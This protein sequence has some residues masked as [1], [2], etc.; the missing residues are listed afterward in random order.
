MD[1]NV[2]TDALG[3][4][5]RTV[6]LGWFTSTLDT[7]YS[8]KLS[9][10]DLPPLPS[11]FASEQSKKVFQAESMKVNNLRGKSPRVTN[12]WT[13]SEKWL[14][15]LASSEEKNKYGVKPLVRVILK[16]YGWSIAKAGVVK[17]LTTALS[18][19]GPILLGYIVKYLENGVTQRNLHRGIL[20]IALL[21]GSSVASAVLN[22]NYNVRT[23]IIK[24]NMQGALVRIVFTRCLSL[25]I[26]AKKELFLSDSQVN[27][28]VQVDVDQVSNC[29][30]SI[31]DLWALPVQIVVACALLYLN[32]KVAFLAGMFIIIIMIPLNSM[33]A[34]RIGSATDS[35]MKA[36]DSRIKIVT[37][38][39][40]NVVSMK[41][42]GLEGAVLGASGAFRKNEVHHLAM[43]K[44][45]DAVCVFLW[46]LTPV[47]VPFA[48]FLTT[49]YMN[50]DLSAS[51]VIT[52]IALLNMLIFPMNALP[53]VINGFME[54]RVSL[55]RLAKVLSSEDGEQLHVQNRFMRKSRHRVTFA[56]PSQ[57]EQQAVLT[58]AGG[59]ES[60]AS[61]GEGTARDGMALNIPTT[62][63]SWSTTYQTKVLMNPPLDPLSA[64]SHQQP[65]GADLEAQTLSPLL[66]GSSNNTVNAEGGDIGTPFA[67]SINEIKLRPGQ[68]MGVIGSTGSGK[69]SLLLGILG[70]IRGHKRLNDTGITD[71]LNIVIVVS[72][73]R[74]TNACLLHCS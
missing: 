27:N 14:T 50:I 33:I 61:S 65:P 29:V 19:V 58:S 71:M 66:E 3:E 37:E 57:P 31:H 60:R 40:G 63:W 68:L 24:T 34:K 7:G 64:L 38:A 43:R 45:L 4:I 59:Q 20:L 36:K 53:W 72:M 62:V 67:V 1:N 69:S 18:F 9:I 30:K 56:D 54:A 12:E 44:Y 28:L 13:H 70:E 48:T 32:I 11:N 49:A 21:A 22:T 42:T 10:D 26:I 16:C 41:M 46:A 23:L 8:K 6:H 25:P 52:A 55:R 51:D 39:L 2:S 15:H 74:G 73:H 17:A 35:L 5:N 47:I